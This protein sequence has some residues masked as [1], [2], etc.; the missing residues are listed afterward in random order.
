MAVDNRIVTK[1]GL[2]DTEQPWS[3]Y[4]DV[5]ATQAIFQQALA[6][7]TPDW[8]RWPEDYK[9]FAKEEFE[10]HREVSETLALDYKIEDQAELINK[11]ARMVNPM[12]TTAFIQKLRAFG[13]KCFTVYNGF[14]PQTVALWCLPPKQ[15]AKARYIC[16]MQT[17]AMY[18]WSVLR[19]DKYGKPDNERFRGWRTVLVQL[20]EKEILTEAQAHKIFGEASHNHIYG[21]YHRSLWEARNKRR[22]TDAQLVANDF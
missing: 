15:N 16:F 19:T 21:R 1:D 18:E 7:G 11:A 5:D 8:V 6:G 3:G 22:Y 14:P 17:P 4:R 20:V 10:K 2:K 13:I 12:S 9:N